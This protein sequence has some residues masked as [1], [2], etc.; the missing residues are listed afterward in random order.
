LRRYR[1]SL[2]ISKETKNKIL[3]FLRKHESHT[4]V[5]EEAL[6][7]LVFGMPEIEPEVRTLYTDLMISDVNYL[8][9]IKRFIKFFV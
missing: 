2:F 6:Y 7:Q 5:I 4:E 8:T 9:K 3:W 1:S